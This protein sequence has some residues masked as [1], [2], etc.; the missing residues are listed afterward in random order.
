MKTKTRIVIISAVLLAL[1]AAVRF[2]D[3]GTRPMHADEAVQ[4]FIFSDLLEQGDY[5]YD[6]AHFHGPL[7]HFVNL[8]LMRALGI[9]SLDVLQAWQFRLQPALAG[10]LLVILAGACAQDRNKQNL[11]PFEKG[12]GFAY[13][14]RSARWRAMLLAAVSPMLVYFSRMAI[15]ETLLAVCALA[16]PLA[17]A[18]WLEGRKMRWLLAAAVALGCLHATKE[19]WCVITF[20]WAVAAVVLWPRKVRG[21]VWGAEGWRIA[22]GAAVAMGVSFLLHSNFGRRPEGFVDAWR[23]LFAYRTGG[24]HEKGWWYFLTD[25]LGFYQAGGWVAGEGVI[26]LLA[27][28]GGVAAWRDFRFSILDLSGFSLRSERLDAACWWAKA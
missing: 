22:L 10:L 24:G 7:P 12:S 28:A 3:L 17:V 20:S 4:A 16:V 9:R 21:A 27:L 14:G 13:C 26:S 18:H 11:T 5:R 15:H 23:S 19:T 2:A 25:C 1:A 8:A 6:P